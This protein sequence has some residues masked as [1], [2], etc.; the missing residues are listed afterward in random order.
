MAELIIQP[1]SADAT[2]P[3]A[4]P[5]AMW[6]TGSNLQ[7]T[8][9]ANSQ[10]SIIRFDFSTLPPGSIISAASLKLYISTAGSVG[11]AVNCYEVTQTGWVE[12]EVSWNHYKDTTHWASGG[13]DYTVT[14]GASTNFTGGSLEWMTW[15]V[16]NLVKHFQASH[17]CIANML[18]ITSDTSAISSFRSRE[19]GADTTQCPKLTITYTV[20]TSRN[21]VMIF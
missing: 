14:D 7:L 17:A 21:N 16:L 13:G 1:S 11:V 9:T 20:S 19:Y 8:G 4:A 15:N 12:S 5:D 3:E 10:R 18:L 6:G 2:L